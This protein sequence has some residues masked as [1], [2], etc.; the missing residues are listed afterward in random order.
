MEKTIR[1]LVKEIQVDA[2]NLKH[3]SKTGVI[4]GSL[5]LSIDNVATR[6]A[7]QFKTNNDLITTEICVLRERVAELEDALKIVNKGI[8]T[9]NYPMLETI[10][11]DIESLINKGKDNGI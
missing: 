10:N 7:S 6:Y 9:M 3:I 8:K 1:E 2:S 4:N 5:L 11:V